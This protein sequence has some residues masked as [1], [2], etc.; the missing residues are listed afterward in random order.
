MFAL[1]RDFQ[2]PSNLQLKRARLINKQWSA[3]AATLLWRE[4]RI[5]VYLYATHR[6]RFDALLNSRPNGILDNVKKLSI[7]TELT[8]S[9]AS[10]KQQV[11]SA[12]LRLFSALPQDNLSSLRSIRLAIHPDVVC[13]LLGT[14]SHLRELKV[15]IDEQSPDGLPGSIHAR[16][17]LSQMESIRVDV[18][19]LHHQTYRGMGAWFAHTFKLR[20]MDIIGR[21]ATTN[22]FEGW[23]PLTQP[24]MIKLRRLV[25]RRI[26]LPDTPTG[27]VHHLHT[28]S[29]KELC[30]RACSNVGPFLVSLA[31]AYKQ[32]KTP[33][34]KFFSHIADAIPVNAQ[35]ASAELI[36]SVSGLEEVVVGPM[37]DDVMDLQCLKTSG[38]S[39]WNLQ[40]YCHDEDT[41][42]YSFEDLGQL[43]LIC[44]KLESLS[45]N[46]G[47]L[48]STFDEGGLSEPFRLAGQTDYVKKLVS[49]LQSSKWKDSY[50][51]PLGS[52]FPIQQPR[53]TSSLRSCYAKW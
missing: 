46:L 11:T 17:S 7:L 23:A 50:E 38:E 53:L 24:Q 39:L 28:P 52:H 26:H 42:Y 2:M 1:T 32:T 40:L 49:I 13:A 14:Q 9:N 51:R 43:K 22:R 41:V 33:A 29:L 36:M 19:G 25:L 31:Q 10:Q 44:P 4:L 15:L 35:R 21:P 47:D 16:G 34:L 30:L 45:I 27:I 20:N 12:L 18:F 48:T 6:H 5:D 8:T 37:S 3:V